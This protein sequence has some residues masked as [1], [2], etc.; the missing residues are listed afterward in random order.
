VIAKQDFDGGAMN[1]VS[2]FD[3]ATGNLDGGSGDFFGVGS[4]ANW[5]QGIPPGAPFN[6]VDD[7][8]VSLSNPANAP[9]PTDSEAV[10]GQAATLENDFFGISDTGGIELPGGPP[11]TASWTFNV[12]RA[13]DLSLSIDMGAQANDAFGGFPTDALIE[14]EY[15]FDSGTSATAFSI[16]PDPS[17]S[18]SYTYRPM[19]STFGPITGA[20]GP[21]VASGANTVTKIAVD[22]GTAAD[23][24]ALDKSPPEGTRAGK[25]DTFRTPLTGTGNQLMLTVTANLPFEAMAFDNILIEGEGSVVVGLSGDYNDNGAVDAADYV[26]WRDG[27]PLMNEGDNPGT[28]NQ[29]D[30][31]FWRARFGA[32]TAGLGTAQVPEPTSVAIGWCTMVFIL[33]ARW[34]ARWRTA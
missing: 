26:L 32:T 3:P 14:F 10:Y 29:A 25:L 27:G 9:F 7:S 8:I 31:D 15:Q 5:P 12:A 13:S 28:V 23:N 6:L 30:Y 1:L 11:Y 20:N 18:T 2:G 4:I 33:A 24:R 16:A 34:T 22:T 21:L 19:D 17:L